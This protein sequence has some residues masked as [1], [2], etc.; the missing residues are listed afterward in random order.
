MQYL[1]HVFHALTA[2]K[3]G[4]TIYDLCDPLL[5][6]P[7][8]GDAHLRKFYQTAIANPLLRP[9]LA[10]AGLPR[11]RDPSQFGAV[12]DAIV[13]ARDQQTPDWTAIGQPVAH[14]LDQFTQHHPA[15]KPPAAPK[16]AVPM[17]EIDRIVHACA[18]HLLGTFA[19]HG[20]IPAYAAFNL[21]GDPDFRGREFLIAL[22]GLNARTYK[23]STLLFN[24]ARAFIAGSPAAAVLNPPW[25]GLA[26]QMW[27]PVQIRHRSA[28]Y[29]AF[30][31]E[32][33][34]DFLASGLATPQ[35]SDAARR[36]L[37]R[38]IGFCLRE[39][40]EQVPDLR[41]GMPFDVVTAIAPSPH[42]RFSRFFANI[43]S[44]LGF[45]IYVPDCDTTA[46]S[47]SAA[48]QF[49]SQDPILEQPMID[50]YASYQ[51][52]QGDNREM[53]TVPINDNIA[54]DGGIMTWIENLNGDRPYGNDL[55]PTLNLDVLE[56][57]FRNCARWK[58]VDTP[59]RLATVRRIVDFQRR[60]VETDAFAD[61]RSHI[62][63]LPELYCAYFGRCHAAL[64][65]LPAA[66]QEAI[67]PDRSFELIR[68][69]VI[70]YV[71]DELLTAEIN[72]FDAA[73]ALLA[74]AKLGAEPAAFA[75]A[76]SCIARS[77]GEGGRGR[78]FKAYEWN[79]MKTPTRIL[80]GGPEVTSAFVL[81]ALVHARRAMN[82][83]ASS[84]SA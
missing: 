3:N 19:R 61:P 4:P 55:D 33:L 47:L 18:R 77:F 54:F 11:L 29:D 58:I 72:A 35:E 23:N 26:E 36:T 67:D 63:Y 22:R 46:C 45:E 25:S 17:A 83:A 43:K 32:A 60:L 14:L 16:A 50:F 2:A 20:F 53:L 12:R 13:A 57:C 27:S 65:S 51:I 37:D 84:V 5:G 7:G 78:P 38:L 62:Y 64:R 69:H 6:G 28:Y 10:R 79:K 31:A 48:S 30:Y 34:M 15:R 82:A 40:R 8:G 44:D 70:A 41:D 56:L 59:Q 81:S 75:P 1:S 76:L 80:V 9:L 21:T 68:R 49:G 71:R 39:S 42:A 66:A 74:L 73:L 52:G 24:L